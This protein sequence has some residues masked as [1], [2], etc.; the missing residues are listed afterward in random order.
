MMAATVG[1]LRHGLQRL[2]PR[3]WAVRNGRVPQLR[4]AL[5]GADLPIVGDPLTVFDR[6]SEPVDRPRTRRS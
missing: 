2:L 1:N 5:G 6:R 4:E 3:T